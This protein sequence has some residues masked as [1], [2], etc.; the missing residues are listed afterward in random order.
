[1]SDFDS[2]GNDRGV[3]PTP[4]TPGYEPFVPVPLWALRR[5]LADHE[6]RCPSCA[7]QVGATCVDDWYRR[8]LSRWIRQAE[9]SPRASR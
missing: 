9:V 7:G 5:A 2:R 8:G 3:A 1:M 4:P 6:A